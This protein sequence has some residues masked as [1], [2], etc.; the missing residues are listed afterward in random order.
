[1]QVADDGVVE[2]LE[3]GAVQADVVGGPADAEGVAAGAQ[4]ADEVGQSLS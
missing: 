2:V 3:P 4:F 1:M